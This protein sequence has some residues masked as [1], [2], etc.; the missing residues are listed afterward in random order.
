[1]LYK[2]GKSFS[3]KPYK[4]SS[5]DLAMNLKSLIALLASGDKIY[6]RVTAGVKHLKEGADV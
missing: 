4:V 6:L 1:M 3:V 2:D 5:I